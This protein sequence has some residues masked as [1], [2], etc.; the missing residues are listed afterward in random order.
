VSSSFQMVL[1][2]PILPWKSLDDKLAI[3][4]G[5]YL[6]FRVKFSSEKRIIFPTRQGKM[7]YI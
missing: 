1:Q 3:T 7:G 5:V 2:D 4:V 6:Q